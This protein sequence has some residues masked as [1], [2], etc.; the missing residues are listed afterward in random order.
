M[1]AMEILEMFF[2]IYLYLFFISYSLRFSKRFDVQNSISSEDTK[3]WAIASR[4]GV[5]IL[6]P[7]LK[8]EASWRNILRI[9]K[10]DVLLLN[11]SQT[12]VA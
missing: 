7:F 10:W 6:D 9:H 11:T 4:S 1:L 2:I 5:M 8:K 12:T 3:W